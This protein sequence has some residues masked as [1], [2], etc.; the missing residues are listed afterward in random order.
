M[1][2]PKRNARIAHR[3]LSVRNV[4][5]RGVGHMSLPI[6]PRLAREISD[7]LSQLDTDGST[8]THGI[9]RIVAGA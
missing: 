5:V 4:L 9:T 1:I 3:D 6:H 2:V 7:A 8:L